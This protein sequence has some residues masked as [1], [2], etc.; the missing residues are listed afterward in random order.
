METVPID[1]HCHLNLPE[2]FSDPSAEIEYANS[3]GIHT[4]IVVGTDLDSSRRAVEIAD[5]HACVFAV[6]GIHPNSS[7]AFTDRWGVEIAAMLNHPKVVAI[8]EIGLDYHWDYAT[9]AQQLA[10]LQAQLTIA[11]EAAKPIVFHCRE[12][13]PDLLD[14]LE[15]RPPQP[16]LLHCYAGD[17]ADATRAIALSCYF[18]VDG[19]ITYKK[20]TA[21]REIVAQ[22]PRDRIVVETDAPFLTPEPFRG[23][24]N[25]PGYVRYVNEALAKILEMSVEECATQTDA[26]A[27]A[28]FGSLA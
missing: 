16:Y 5:E 25:R 1:T 12:A 7:A 20:A 28:F 13:Y 22:L 2:Y 8:G 21:L 11:Q 26:N 6:V 24:Q 14:L 27:R 4:L 23:K 3:E 17:E 10:A 19:P 15:M 18:G 9:P